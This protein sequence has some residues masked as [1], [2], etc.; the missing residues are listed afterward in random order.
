MHGMHR[1]RVPSFRA[2][3]IRAEGMSVVAFIV[4][5][6]KRMPPGLAG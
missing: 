1:I 3:G 4:E 2:E 5:W 6:M